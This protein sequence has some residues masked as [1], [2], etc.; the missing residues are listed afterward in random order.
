MDELINI[1]VFVGT[2]AVFIY[3]AIRK[4]KKQP[5][6]GKPVPSVS[7]ES[8]FGIQVEPITE[9]KVEVTDEPMPYV[10]PEYIEEPKLKKT[11]KTQEIGAIPNEIKKNEIS[12]PIIE[13]ESFDLKSAVVYTEIL[14]RKKI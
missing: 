3:S 10:K 7:L 2:I 8:L 4:T 1:L 9:P 12:D 11:L 5:E 13:E 14:K 6:K